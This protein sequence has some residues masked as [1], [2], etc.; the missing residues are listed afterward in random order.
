MQTVLQ[1][2]YKGDTM[3]TRDVNIHTVERRISAILGGTLLLQSLTRRSPALGEKA[4]AAALLY[5][6]ISGH[7]F[8]YQG[9]GISTANEQHGQADNTPEVERSITIEKSADE[10]YRFWRA[11]QNLSQIMGDLGEVTEMGNGL[12]HWV[13][14]GPWNR[15]IEWDTQFVE[16]RPGE[17]LRWKSVDGSP[18][19]N[20]GSVQFRSAPRDW[21][22]EVTLHFRFDAPGGTLSNNVVN[23][24][25]II[26][27]LLV[28]KALRRFKSL[29]ESGEYPTLKHNPA[30]RPSSYADTNEPPAYAHS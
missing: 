11:P 4:L 9:L 21:G 30:A 27:R 13:V 3:A 20:E 14:Q 7:S 24:V 1:G 19:P 6:G 17:L 16:E 25:I 5:R 18:Y 12:T 8:L 28:E 22:T 26:P 15:R 29:A 23:S 10:L 2:T